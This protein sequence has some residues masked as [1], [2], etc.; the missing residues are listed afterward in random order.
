MFFKGFFE[1]C[2]NVF[3]LKRAAAQ[4]GGIAVEHV[5]LFITLEISEVV[6]FLEQ[7]GDVFFDLRFVFFV[8]TLGEVSDFDLDVAPVS[9]SFGKA[10]IFRLSGI[11]GSVCLWFGRR[12]GICGIV[13]CL[14][15]RF[16][17]CFLNL[18]RRLFGRF[19][20]FLRLFVAC[21]KAEKCGE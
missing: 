7:I 14:R 2:G 18:C 6:P 8:G 15:W 13:F 4:I 1:F 9:G 11:G 16:G 19:F 3:L 21:L 17:L 5:E 10:F 12:S 20:S